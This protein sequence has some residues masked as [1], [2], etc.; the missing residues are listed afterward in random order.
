M[1]RF[2]IAEIVVAMIVLAQGEAVFAQK[3]TQ[4]PAQT[5]TK[6]PPVSAPVAIPLIEINGQAEAL[7]RQL[8]EIPRRLPG[9]ARLDSREASLKR[10]YETLIARIAD[11]EELLGSNPTLVDVRGEERYWRWYDKTIRTR[12]PMVQAVRETNQ[13]VAFLEQEEQ[14]WSATLRDIA[15]LPGV[16]AVSET[17]HHSLSDIQKFKADALEQRGKALTLQNQL[18]RLDLMARDELDRVNQALGE[19]QQHL[20]ARDAPP[21]WVATRSDKDDMKASAI[22]R[23]IRR[24]V[25]NGREFF[26]QERGEVSAFGLVYLVAFWL[27]VRLRKRLQNSPESHSSVSTALSLMQ[28]P[29]ALAFFAAL[30]FYIPLLRRAPIGVMPLAVLSLLIPVVLMAVMIWREQKRLSLGVISLI[31][32]INGLLETLVLSPELKRYLTALFAA[33]S[34]AAFVWLARYQRASFAKP[35]RRQQKMFI[36]GLYYV[37]GVFIISLLATILGYLTLAQVLRQTTLMSVFIGTLVFIAAYSTISIGSAVM[38]VTRISKLSI[39]RT[40]GPA[41][42]TWITRFIIAYGFWFWTQSTLDLLNLNDDASAF[43]TRV[44]KAQLLPLIDFTLGD[45]LAL[46]AIGVVGYL[47]AKAIRI[48]LR[49][50]VLSRFSLHRGIPELISSSTFYAL[51]ALVVMTAAVAAGVRLDKFTVLTGAL[52]IGLGF[53]LQNV[54]NN[55]T[56]GLILQFER[57]INIGDFL[58]VGNVAGTVSRIGIRSSSLLTPQGAEVIIPNATFVSGQVTNWTLHST[59]RRV[60]IPIRV[61]YGTD[62]RRV[63]ELLLDIVGQSPGVLKDPPPTAF[64]KGF[65]ESALEFELMFW[66]EISVLG[67]YRNEIAIAIDS[68]FRDAG[69]EIPIPQREIHVHNIDATSSTDSYKGRAVGQIAGGHTKE[70]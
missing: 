25:G 52:G 39:I 4:T 36:Y 8:A 7:Q 66:S 17:V 3:S 28:I 2:S 10:D 1:Q 44:L 64:F 58:D 27:V 30:P 18:T 26:E 40:Q 9:K 22:D 34:A 48:T 23:T 50:D 31:L 62:P 45:L 37:S 60:D 14:K 6:P 35:V 24:S 32:V 13:V 54:V 47:L 63:N 19:F 68:G 21:L 33:S 41:I 11:T 59:C 43:L 70:S 42:E 53:G 49:D 67:Q 56:S 51:M 61:A 46:V 16:S 38:H 5:P 15:S 55:F 20:L 12:T 65:G 69:I 57:P 29:A